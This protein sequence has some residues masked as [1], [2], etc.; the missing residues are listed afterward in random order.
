MLRDGGIA[1]QHRHVAPSNRKSFPM[2]DLRP[3]LERAIR[4]H[5]EQIAGMPAL[6]AA[7]TDCWQNGL[8]VAVQQ[9]AHE[10]SAAALKR[11]LE[12]EETR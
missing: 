1:V 11:I 12:E 7:G 5:E 9:Y 3:G 4:W 10:R 6:Y 2:T 8:W